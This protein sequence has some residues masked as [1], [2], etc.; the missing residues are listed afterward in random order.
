MGV[1]SSCMPHL[2]GD[3]YEE[4]GESAGIFDVYDIGELL[5]SG[6]F[7]QVRVCRHVTG[8]SKRAVKIIDTQSDVLKQASGYLSPQQEAEILQ[9]LHHPHIVEMLDYYED[10]RWIFIVL[11]CIMGGDLFAAIANPKVQVT[12]R[13]IANVG[14]Q[15]F[16]ALDY[17]HKS[18]IVHRDVKA[19]NLLL[20]TNPQQT[21]HWHVKLIDFGLAMNQEPRAPALIRYFSDALAGHKKG[22]E[23]ICG[24]AYY[25]APEVWYGD[26]DPKLDV[27]AAAVVLYIALHGSFPFWDR[28]P[29]KIEMLVVDPNI[30]PS[31][32][33][34][35]GMECPGYMPSLLARNFL[36]VALTKD[37]AARPSASTAMADAFFRP[38]VAKGSP[39]PPPRRNAP[40][41]SMS[42]Q[43]IGPKA[44]QQRNSRS[45][46]LQESADGLPSPGEPEQAIPMPIRKKAGRLTARAPIPPAMEASRTAALESLR[47]RHAAVTD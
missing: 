44:Q 47:V 45:Q 25:C 20:L 37:P 21:N 4:A 28:D 10:S 2:N 42:L 34:A 3:D 24:T 5:G 36:Q 8:S 15:V 9:E 1:A 19:E 38:P 22:E 40:G 31:F 32:R 11:E 14:S 30:A 17:L 39:Q 16:N 41:K 12:E 27:W 43:G 35:C 6:T 18:A 23:L 7:G 29:D 46:S 13:T 33:P 26:Y